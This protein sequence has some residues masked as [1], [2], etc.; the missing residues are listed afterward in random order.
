MRD[1]RNWYFEIGDSVWFL[2]WMFFFTLLD[3]PPM[4]R[5]YIAGLL[6]EDSSHDADEQK[7]DA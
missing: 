4:P 2:L 3:I 6:G 5:S 1:T 7:S